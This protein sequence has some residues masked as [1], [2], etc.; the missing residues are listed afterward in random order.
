M[1]NTIFFEFF[2][3]IVGCDHIIVTVSLQNTMI[4]CLFDKW[5]TKKVYHRI[6]QIYERRSV[7]VDHLFNVR[8]QESGLAYAAGA[9]ARGAPLAY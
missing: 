1:L 3:F 4:S 7:V 2:L 9:P 6:P 8:L 5:F